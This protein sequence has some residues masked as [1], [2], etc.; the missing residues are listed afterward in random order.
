ML[1]HC[2]RQDKQLRRTVM[3]LS[4]ALYTFKVLHAA[5]HDDRAENIF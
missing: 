2:Q 5:L 3:I 1:W 4:I